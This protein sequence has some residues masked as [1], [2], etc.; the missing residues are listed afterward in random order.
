MGVAQSAKRVSCGLALE[1][2][3]HRFYTCLGK[4]IRLWVVRTWDLVCDIPR[5]AELS[6]LC[7]HIL[8]AIVRAEYFGNSML[9]E[10]LFEQ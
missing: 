4:S 2:M 10:H 3:L 7:T 1:C 8:R 5:G 9:Q 6:E